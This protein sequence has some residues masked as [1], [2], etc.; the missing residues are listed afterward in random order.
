MD[1]IYTKIASL[2]K[3]LVLADKTSVFKLDGV[4]FIPG[5]KRYDRLKQQDI[6]YVKGDKSHVIVHLANGTKQSISTHLGQF[7]R[8]LDP[9]WF[10]RTSRSHI[11]NLCYVEALTTR[12]MIVNK[13]AI[14]LTEAYR[15]T[16]WDQLPIVRLKSD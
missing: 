5:M 14:P 10:V 8:Y 6:C 11:V 15:T 4:L 3:A 12:S 1:E 13:K 9:L 7:M 2:E 16:F